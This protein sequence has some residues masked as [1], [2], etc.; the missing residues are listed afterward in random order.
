MRRN[1]PGGVNTYYAD[2]IY[3]GRHVLTAIQ[4]RDL[5]AVKNYADEV[6][7]MCIGCSDASIRALFHH[8]MVFV[9]RKLFQKRPTVE[10]YME[11]LRHCDKGLRSVQNLDTDINMFFTEFFLIKM[12]LTRM[13]IN[14]DFT[15]ADTEDI[16]TTA[17][18]R[19][20]IC[21]HLGHIEAEYLPSMRA[22]GAMMF[23]VCKARAVESTDRRLAVQYIDR[24]MNLANDGL[25]FEERRQNLESYRRKVV[26][27]QTSD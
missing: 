4:E 2:L 14:V 20:Q 16:P 9:Y 18:D 22:R 19:S 15:L 25:I 27:N 10:I 13:K 6:E 11:I 21:S 24:A 8:R 26:E 3:H 23:H 1:L 12:C 17:A 5:Q 7:M